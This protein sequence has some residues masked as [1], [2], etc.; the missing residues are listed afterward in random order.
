MQSGALTS[1]DQDAPSALLMTTVQ[2]PFDPSGQELSPESQSPD[3][4][5]AG[6]L[7]PRW[8]AV[9]RHSRKRTVRTDTV[10]GG[11]GQFNSCRNCCSASLGRDSIFGLI[12][13]VSLCH[14]FTATELCEIFSFQS[15]E[16]EGTFSTLHLT[17]AHE[18]IPVNITPGHCPGG[19]EIHPSRDLLFSG[20]KEKKPV[21][22]AGS[23]FSRFFLT[24]EFCVTF[25][26]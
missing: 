7:L 4:P 17:A 25:R 3:C 12:R 9:R 10:N 24:E 20:I 15:R 19:M 6:A 16:Q 1:Y 21:G 11:N 23:P 14:H 2:V 26:G 13:F 5:Q 18:D 22:K 8:R